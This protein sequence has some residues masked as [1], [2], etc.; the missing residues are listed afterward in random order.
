M[1]TQSGDEE[2]IHVHKGDESMESDGKA[3]FFVIEQREYDTPVIL[4][5]TSPQFQGLIQSFFNDTGSA[6]ELSSFKILYSYAFSSVL[7]STPRAASEDSC[8]L[9]YVWIVK[10]V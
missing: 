1:F 4:H 5:A 3:E 10:Y 2:D 8:L 7:L 9:R 6:V